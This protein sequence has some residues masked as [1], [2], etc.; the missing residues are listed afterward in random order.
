[1]LTSYGHSPGDLDITRFLNEH[2]HLP[3]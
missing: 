1:L 3:T 2:F